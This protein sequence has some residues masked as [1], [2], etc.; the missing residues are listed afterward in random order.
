[1]ASQIPHA[2]EVAARTR[3]ARGWAFVGKLA[4]RI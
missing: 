3:G 4:L 2:N 1:M